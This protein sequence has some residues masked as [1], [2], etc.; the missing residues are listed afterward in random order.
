MPKKISEL[1]QTVSVIPDNDLLAIVSQGETKRITLADALKYGNQYQGYDIKSLSSF[2]D[3]TYST[4]LSNSA[5]WIYQ[6][7]DIKSVSANWQN[8]Y[9]LIRLNSATTWNYQGTDIKVLTSYW[10]DVY[11]T[12]FSNSAVNWNYQGTDVKILTS[13]WAA[14]HSIF[15]KVS[16]SINSLQSNLSSIWQDTTTTVRANSA[17]K[18]N[19]Q[20][21][22]IKQIS[23]I[24]QDAVTTV[25]T[26]SAAWLNYT[27]STLSSLTGNWNQSQTVVNSNSAIWNAG[28]SGNIAIY[29][30]S[31]NWDTAYYNL[32]TKVSKIGDIMSGDLTIQKSPADIA[33]LNLETTGGLG[34]K[35]KIAAETTNK[36]F[37]KTTSFHPLVLG[38][39]N[40]DILYVNPDGNVGVNTDSPNEKLTV[41]GSIVAKGALNTITSLALTNGGYGTVEAKSAD[42]ASKT[43]IVQYG[44]GAVGTLFSVP[45]ESQ[46]QLFF[47]T[48]DSA[49]IGSNLEIPIIIGSGAT[50]KMRISPTGNVG[51]NQTN[52]QSKLD[53]T[54]N[55]NYTGLTIKQD[56][57]GNSFYVDN[58][59]PF[60]IAN[61][62]YVGIGKDVP[63]ALLDIDGSVVVNGTLSSNNIIYA[64]GG[65]SDIWN[66]MLSTYSGLSSGYVDS[67]YVQTEIV[68]LKD[69]LVTALETPQAP[70]VIVASTGIN[71]FFHAK[72]FLADSTSNINLVLP[73]SAAAGTEFSVIRKN[74]GNVTFVAG[75]NVALSSTPDNTFTK[76]AFR[77]SLATAYCAGSGQWYL[78]G[79]L[80]N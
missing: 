1:N 19:Y 70:T 28:G 50:E 13:D 27:D 48:C 65:N 55:L 14:T 49:I 5:S 37:I 9:T 3:T 16:S 69:Q 25:K 71:S 34:S 76:L 53:I 39:A 26:N 56:G 54:A 10:D 43:K 4:V 15:S 23:G 35:L 64:L 36:S 11:N 22:D 38:A 67:N 80:I 63:T 62:G 42:N 24:W 78:F 30:L 72:T 29:T 45:L 17:V 6:G 33:A 51:I 46:G 18:W 59:Q 44:S 60:V 73:A 61:N 52:P 40:N 58:T 47:D 75:L 74:T 79:D 32:S 41:D 68:S 57:T 31:A 8:S 66:N 2:W 12:V 77:N 7:T 20:G 21:T